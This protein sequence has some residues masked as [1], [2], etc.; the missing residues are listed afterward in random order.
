MRFLALATIALLAACGSSSEKA[1]AAKP[2]AAKPKPPD[3]SRHFPQKDRGEVAIVGDN[4]MGSKVLPGGNVAE[5]KTG[6]K[7]WRLFLVQA[8][9]AEAAAILLLDYK[10]TL[11]D[12]KYVPAFGAYFGADGQTPV[13]VLQKGV[14]LAGIAGLSEKD[15]DPIAREFAARLN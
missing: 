4:V 13:F 5:Y 14:Y 1:P 15:A 8:K 6:A 10:S 3:L 7:T 12:P 9:S 2:A 11:K